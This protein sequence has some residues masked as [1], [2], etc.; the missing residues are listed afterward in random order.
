MKAIKAT[1]FLFSYIVLAWFLLSWLEISFK[2]IYSGATYN[3]YNIIVNF[4]NLML[5]GATV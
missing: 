5:G 1:Y 4:I 2:S 3:N